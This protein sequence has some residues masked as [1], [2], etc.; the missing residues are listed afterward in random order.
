MPAVWSEEPRPADRFACAECLDRHRAAR[1]DE[2]LDRDVAV[3]DDVERV[4]FV[5]FAEELRAGIEVHVPGA[6]REQREAVVAEPCEERHVREELVE[7]PRHAPSAVARIAATSSVMSI[8]TGHQ[9]MQ[10]PQPTQPDESNWSNQV[11]SLW[12]I[13]WR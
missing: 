4:G 13:H 5:A 10:R 12:V 1:R 8:P 9:V 11:P 7:R 6:A 2:R 3:T